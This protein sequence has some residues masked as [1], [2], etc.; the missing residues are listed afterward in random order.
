MDTQT[1]FHYCTHES[2]MVDG[3]CNEAP[4]PLPPVVPVSFHADIW[5]FPSK[6]S[7]PNKSLFTVFVFLAVG[8][9]LVVVFEV[10]GAFGVF[11]ECVDDD[12]DDDTDD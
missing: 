4:T 8:V 9:A 10:D 1:L 5:L 3:S 2:V 12:D 11:S 7:P 6:P